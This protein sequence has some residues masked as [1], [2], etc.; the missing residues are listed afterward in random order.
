[1]D[2][3]VGAIRSNVKL[4]REPAGRSGVSFAHIRAYIFGVKSSSRGKITVLPNEDFLHGAVVMAVRG[5]AK[6]SVELSLTLEAS[7]RYLRWHWVYRE[8]K[9]HDATQ[10][11]GYY[12]HVID[13]DKMVFQERVVCGFEEPRQL[14]RGVW[15][16]FFK[17][18]R[19]GTSMPPSLKYPTPSF[20]YIGVPKPSE[21]GHHIWYSLSIHCKRDNKMTR[22][23]RL[24][25][26]VTGYLGTR[27]PVSPDFKATTVMEGPEDSGE[28][29]R[30]A[31]WITY[32]PCDQ[33][34]AYFVNLV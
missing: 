1:L 15:V 5:N 9:C 18:T 6:E 7:C 17:F 25:I 12:E 14:A 30:E 2:L 21:S 4:M 33:L 13:E 28:K 29:T 8:T 34:P 11:G 32:P 10:S 3:V 22:L 31:F 20:E 23:I 19:T 16:M 24:P 27:V 26:T